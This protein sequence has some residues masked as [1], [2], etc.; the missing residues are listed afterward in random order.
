MGFPVDME[1]IYSPTANNGQIVQARDN[2]N[3]EEINYSY[4]RLGQLTAAQMTGPER[5]SADRC[6]LPVCGIEGNDWASRMIDCRA[7]D[8]EYLFC[9][10]GLHFGGFT[11]AGSRKTGVCATLSL[12]QLL[13]SQGSP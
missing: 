7:V 9:R 12:S 4:D 10:V 1:Y 2:R 6:C 3:A 13:I 11:A 8:R 5:G